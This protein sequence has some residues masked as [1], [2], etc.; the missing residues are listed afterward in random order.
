M[1]PFDEKF[2]TKIE[3][4]RAAGVEPYP[5]GLTV[6]HT[7]TE[8]HARFVGVEM[9]D[10]EPVAIGG[11]VMFRNRMG[12][13]MFLRI[14]DRGEPSVDDVDSDGTPVKRGG[15][16]QVFVRKNDVGEESYERLK[17]LDIGDFL[18][19]RG[20]MMRTRTGELSVRAEE[21]CLASK[22]MTPFPDRFHG[23]ADV[24]LR[25]RQRYVD[26]FINPDTRETFRR[27]SR[28]VQQ[29]REFFL[30]RDFLE[31]ETPMLHAIPGGAAARPFVTHHNT[32]DMPLYLRIAPELYLKRLVVGGLERVFE[33]NRSFRNEGV[34]PR[35]NPEFTMIEFYMAWATYDDLMDLTEELLVEV[36]D[37]V[38]GTRALSFGD[39]EMD[40]SPPFRRADM[41][42]LIAENTEL[43]LADLEDPAAMEAYWRA[44][45][46]VAEGERLPTS[47]GKW[48][49]L[50]FETHVEHT[51][52]NPTFV[53]GFPT[54]ISPLARRSDGDPS[55]VDRFELFA[56]TWELGNAFSELN[57]PVDQ[58]GRFEAQAVARVEGDDE[59][60]YFDHDYI[61]ALTYAMPPTAG[62][63][64]GIDRVV[65]LLT[66]RRH[67]KEVLLFPTLR[68]E[69]WD[70]DS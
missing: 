53:T 30:R 69:Q 17:K 5:N 57:D 37:T 14:Q 35:H 22:V 23:V 34:S 2:L 58:A 56:A 9:P 64:I 3:E 48:W 12:K 25:S 55:R 66:D 20:T 52:I 7:S 29:F 36:V 33:I 19:A 43:S 8:L 49:E 67:I 38:A 15:M 60:M 6:T 21:A 31:V 68:P 11:R 10:P 63:G 41:D 42:A 50:L 61:R 26:L 13:V 39:L 62:M 70:A 28:I 54:E 59:S 18:W 51:L 65:Q 47:R 32:L 44:R 27:R 46:D 16:I 24:E 1:Y 40:W 45:H 4:L